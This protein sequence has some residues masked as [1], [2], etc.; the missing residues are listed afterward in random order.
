MGNPCIGADA[1]TTFHAQS[2]FVL[3]V[4]GKPGAFI[5]MGD[6]WKK[7]DLRNSVLQG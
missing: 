7:E 3:P 6:R 5:F 2:T 4:M 1:D